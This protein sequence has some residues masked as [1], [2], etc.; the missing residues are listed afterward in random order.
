MH[1]FAL[2]ARMYLYTTLQYS[3]AHRLC[4]ELLAKPHRGFQNILGIMCT[5]P[6]LD[7]LADK[8]GAEKGSRSLLAKVRKMQEDLEGISHTMDRHVLAQVAG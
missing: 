7:C 6:R 3:H 4:A 2:I 1:I 5:D 8:Q